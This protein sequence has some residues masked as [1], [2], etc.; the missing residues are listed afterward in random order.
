MLKNLKLSTKIS[1]SIVSVAFMAISAIS[2]L[3]Y[4]SIQSALEK[5]I[6]ENHLTIAENTLDKIDGV[7]YGAYQDI[8]VI[9]EKL[10]FKDY[11]ISPE[12]EDLKKFYNELDKLSYLTGPWDELEIF[13]KQGTLVLSASKD[14]I[15]RQIDEQDEA[16]RF[17]F[18][19]VIKNGK[20]YYSDLVISKD[21]G[22]PTIIFATS[23]KDEESSG[24]PIIG[25]AVGSF[26]W[27]VIQEI[28]EENKNLTHLY[29]NQGVVIGVNEKQHRDDILAENQKDHPAVQSALA[30]QASS[31]VLPSAHNDFNSLTSSIPELGYLG[32]AGNGWALLTEAPISV[33]FAPA[34]KTA[35]D[36]ILLFVPIVVLVVSVILFLVRRYVLKPII[37][38]SK[39]SQ[40]ISHGDLAKRA[41][42]KSQDEIGQLA[43]SFNQ[44]ADSLVNAGEQNKKIIETLPHPLFILNPDGTI[45]S[46]NK[47]ACDFLGREEKE[48]IGKN[49]EN[50]G[51]GGY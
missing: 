49:I 14:N 10:V 19:Y 35:F 24:R 25:V 7:L 17:L 30:G 2:Y 39:V 22:K 31:R 27:P 40:S 32:Y 34:K 8:Q 45:K 36:L 13:T 26:A 16:K 38:L 9:G 50:V 1:L 33:A 4:T 51:G 23:I 46:V 18:D 11:I 6:G 42:V 44:M 15:G 43:A 48:L 37:S 41:E 47:T 21:T 3:A 29:N 28:L 20:T 12:E 5:C